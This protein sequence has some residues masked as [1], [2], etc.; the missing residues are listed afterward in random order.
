MH[1]AFVCSSARLLGN[2]HVTLPS[3][4]VLPQRRLFAI[5]VNVTVAGTTNSSTILT[6]HIYYC[7]RV[8]KLI[9]FIRCLS[10]SVRPKCTKRICFWYKLIVCAPGFHTEW[11]I[12]QM[13][14]E[15]YNG[16][17]WKTDINLVRSTQLHK[18]AINVGRE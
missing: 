15:H 8:E 14:H 6:S 3:A 9:F 18:D 1:F 12:I 5:V 16:I 7:Y 10:L 17:Q 2:P 4:D 13:T 11:K